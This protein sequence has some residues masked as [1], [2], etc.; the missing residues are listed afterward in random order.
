M[1]NKKVL[2]LVGTCIVLALGA[3]V[4][5]TAATK[6]EAKAQEITNEQKKGLTDYFR[7]VKMSECDIQ[8]EVTEMPWSGQVM[9]P[10]VVVTYEGKT[11]TIN[12]DYTLKYSDNIDAGPATVKVKGIGDYRG[13]KKLSFYIKGID[14]GT[15][16]TYEYVDGRVVVYHNGEVVDERDYNVDSYYYDTFVSD[17][18]IETTYIRT[19]VY[20]L[21]GKGKYEGF[22]NFTTESQVKVNNETGE[23]N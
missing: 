13:S 12:K 1:K 11:L 6:S 14:F 19:T 15:E 17:N 22:Y 2:A 7:R 3:T 4:A 20:T 18:G 23:Y 21:Y 5:V 10:S 8:L 16:C 9:T